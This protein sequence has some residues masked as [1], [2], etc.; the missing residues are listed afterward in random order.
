MAKRKTVNTGCAECSSTR[1]STINQV[2]VCVDELSHVIHLVDMKHEAG[3][4]CFFHTE[5]VA[6]LPD[7]KY[8]PFAT[9]LQPGFV[10]TIR[11]EKQ[12][13]AYCT[14]SVTQGPSLGPQKRKPKATPKGAALLAIAATASGGGGSCSCSDGAVVGGCLLG[15]KCKC[16]EHICVVPQ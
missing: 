16:P 3:K 9:M 7:E 2:R 1:L 11:H 10:Y 14:W 12:D 4:G 6:G 13:D 15:Q 5:P 8:L